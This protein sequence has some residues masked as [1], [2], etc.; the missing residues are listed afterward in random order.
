MQAVNDKTVCK[1]NQCY[2]C[3]ACVDI[4][5]K[6]AITIKDTLKAYNA[7]IDTDKCVN[8]D[9]CM[10]VCQQNNRIESAKP[11]HWHQGWCKDRVLRKNGSSGGVC[12]A[13]ATAFVRMGGV[14]CSC[15]FKDGEFGFS[16]ADNLN[17]IEQFVGSKYVKSNPK[18]VYKELRKRM[19]HGEKVLFIGLPCQVAAVKI[20]VGEKL[21]VGLY[22]ADLICHGTPSPQLLEIFLRQYGRS[23]DEIQD[24]RFR[25][26]GGF[27][28]YEGFKGVITTGVTDKYL[29][30]FLN[31]LT[32]TDNCYSCY[33]AKTERVSDLTLGDSWGTNLTREEQKQG[34]SLIL[35]QTEKGV[36]LLKNA[37]LHFEDVDIENA[38]KNNH[39]LYEPSNAPVTRESFFDG[40]TKNKKFNSLVF[41][42][43]PKDCLKQD[44]KCVLIKTGIRKTMC[45][46]KVGGGGGYFGY[47]IMIK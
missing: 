33:Y 3:S 9:V 14:V 44:V 10:R 32:Y 40:I 27:Q 35:V 17:D 37:E 34:V 20:F 4:C 36:E 47:G 26:K 31:S 46:W 30:A 18:G 41:K 7:V 23:L 15:I 42:C 25:I 2:G 6:S 19:Q 12:G 1:L 22:T 13:L 38:I 24:I 11:I 8:C 29:I 21:Q 43:F 45:G 39:Q 28:V 16:F 5:P